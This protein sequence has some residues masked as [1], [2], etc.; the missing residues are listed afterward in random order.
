MKKKVISMLMCFALL[1]A[2][3]A[4]KEGKTGDENGGVPCPIEGLEWGMTVDECLAALSLT[5]EDVEIKSQEG[6]QGTSVTVTASLSGYKAYGYPVG[7]VRLLLS[8]KFF[9]FPVGLRNITIRFDPAPAFEELQTAVKEEVQAYTVE[10][11]NNDVPLNSNFQRYNTPKTLADADQSLV[12]KYVQWDR[13]WEVASEIPMEVPEKESYPYGSIAVAEA[14][15]EAF[16]SIDN[17][18]A[19]I[20]EKAA[21]AEKK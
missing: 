15:G 17:S 11:S 7:I 13:W 1:F 6:E 3:T 19:T 16:V 12:D 14:D 9:G 20:L 10:S 4:C 5:E 21:E 2:L 18:I 8:E